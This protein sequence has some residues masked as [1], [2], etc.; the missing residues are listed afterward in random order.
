MAISANT[1]IEFTSKPF[2]NIHNIYVFIDITIYDHLN[3]SNHQWT[4]PLNSHEKFTPEH[5]Q[6]IYN[7]HVFAGIA[8]YGHSDH[9]TD[10]TIKFASKNRSR[11]YITL[12]CLLVLPYMVTLITKWEHFTLPHGFPRSP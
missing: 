12:I 5:I 10:I 3:H 7:T 1:T 4:S 9:K 6:N 2:Q 8:I 11:T